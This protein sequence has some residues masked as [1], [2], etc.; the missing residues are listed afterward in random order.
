MRGRFNESQ[1]EVG[2]AP[3]LPYSDFSG[4]RN[5]RAGSG[6]NVGSLFKRLESWDAVAFSGFSN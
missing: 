2:L 6:K 5:L 4:S 3:V 1:L